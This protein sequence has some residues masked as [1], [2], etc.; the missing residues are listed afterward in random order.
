MDADGA[1]PITINAAKIAPPDREEK[2]KRGA[3]RGLGAFLYENYTE[4]GP[5]LAIP[6]RYVA[7]QLS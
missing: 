6:R 4:N 2:L 1:L 3:S 7:R 5:L